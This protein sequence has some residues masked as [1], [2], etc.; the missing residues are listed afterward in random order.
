MAYLCAVLALLAVF[1]TAGPPPF[2]PL[3][4]AAL[5]VSHSLSDGYV[6]DLILRLGSPTLLSLHSLPSDLAY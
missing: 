6:G 4:V 2:L 3:Q 5:S 1:N